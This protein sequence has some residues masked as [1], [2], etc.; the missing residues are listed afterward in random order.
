MTAQAS[1]WPSSSWPRGTDQAV[2]LLLGVSSP[3]M[4]AKVALGRGTREPGFKDK[5]SF[6]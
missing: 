6:A 2:A 4:G 3:N 1:S 5:Q